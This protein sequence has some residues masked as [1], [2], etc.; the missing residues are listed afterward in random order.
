M[1]HRTPS[2]QIAPGIASNIRRRS[3]RQPLLSS[4]T[5]CDEKGS[6]RSFVTDQYQDE[7]V[8]VICERTILVVDHPEHPAPS[9]IL[10]FAPIF[11]AHEIHEA[12]QH[13][14]DGTVAP[15]SPIPLTPQPPQPPPPAL[16]SRTLT[17]LSIRTATPP[18]AQV[19]RLPTPD[20]GSPAPQIPGL[21]LRGLS[22]APFRI[23]ATTFLSST[24]ASSRP[25]SVR[26]DSGASEATAYSQLSSHST[27]TVSVDSGRKFLISSV[28]MTNKFT[29]K[30]PLPYPMRNVDPDNFIDE[31][32]QGILIGTKERWTLFRWCLLF[33]VFT[34]LIYSTAGLVYAITT[35]CKSR[36]NF[37]ESLH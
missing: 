6:P 25:Q 26:T 15:F 3:A 10:P 14:W 32:G 17:D 18:T 20:F 36:S 4:D 33:S 30:W 21:F 29:D 35:W 11:S 16:P 5:S 13:T 8:E 2:I 22:F 19:P 27:S 31:D 23:P 24:A 7:D 28:A 37:S 12:H 1:Q 34:V 9:A